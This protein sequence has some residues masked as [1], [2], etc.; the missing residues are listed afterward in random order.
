M[1]TE[2][3]DYDMDV[4]LQKSSER[5]IKLKQQAKSANMKMNKAFKGFNDKRKFEKN[6]ND[7]YCR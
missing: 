4:E 7:M 2:T 5:L 1:L 6:L 3:D